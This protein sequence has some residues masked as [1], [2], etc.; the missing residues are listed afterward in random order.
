[1]GADSRAAWRAVDGGV[2]MDKDPRVG[3]FLWTGCVGRQRTDVTN[4]SHSEI[5]TTHYLTCSPP[6]L[7]ILRILGYIAW[8]VEDAIRRAL[9]TDPETGPA[10]W[11]YA[12]AAH[13]MVLDW[14]T[15]PHSRAILGEVGP[16]RYSKDIS[17]ERLWI[18]MSGRMW[19][20]AVCPTPNARS[21]VSAISYSRPTV[22]AHCFGFCDSAT[23][24][25]IEANHTHHHRYIFE[26]LTFHSI[27]QATH[28]YRDSQDSSRRSIQTSRE[29]T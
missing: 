17:V 13:S 24:L 10:Y 23:C 16:L 14:V 25:C 18:K 2:D 1:M 20:P 4:R 21:Y 28:S 7:I 22:I 8:E 5:G 29:S 3:G 12:A 9:E 11:C 6:T 15:Q 27:A 26:T 19:P